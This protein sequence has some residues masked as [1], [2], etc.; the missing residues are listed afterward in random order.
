MP[1]KCGGEMD[2]RACHAPM[3][4]RLTHSGN[5]VHQIIGGNA[6][7]TCDWETNEEFQHSWQVTFLVDLINC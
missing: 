4:P 7:L 3:K 5:S 1:E 2:L 6:T